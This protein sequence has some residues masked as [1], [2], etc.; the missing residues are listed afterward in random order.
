MTVAMA[1]TLQ[2]AHPVVLQVAA[3]AKAALLLV[4]SPVDT[5]VE[6]CIKK[7]SSLLPFFIM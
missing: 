3:K 4:D 2:V 6:C 7:G 5:L 1:M